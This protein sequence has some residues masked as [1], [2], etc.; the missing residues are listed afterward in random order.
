MRHFTQAIAYTRFPLPGYEIQRM[1]MGDHLNLYYNFWLLKD[2]LTH[3]RNPFSDPYQFTYWG[4]RFFNPQIALFSV[5]FAFLSPMGNGVAFNLVF[6]LSFMLA[7]GCTFLWL[8]KAGISFWP[9][10]LGGTIYCLAPHR[11]S[12]MCGHINGLFYFSFPL[13][14]Y[15]AEGMAGSSKRGYAIWMGGILLI[16]AWTEYH[17]F[18]YTILFLIPYG[19]FLVDRM[20]SAYGNTGPEGIGR[21]LLLL[22][23]GGLGCLVATLAYGH[24]WPYGK[25]YFALI[26]IFA[27]GFYLLG[28]SL[29][30]IF[31]GILTKGSAAVGREGVPVL[32]IPFGLLVLLPIKFFLPIPQFGHILIAL[33][34]AG[35]GYTVWRVGARL[36]GSRLNKTKVR[37]LR[38][39]FFSIL[40]FLLASGGIVV[41]IKTFILKGTIVSR[42]R[43]LAE[44]RY[45]SPH[46]HNLFQRVNYAGESMVYLGIVSLT[47]VVLSM[48][49]LLANLRTE[50][51]TG[52]L[53]RQERFWLGIFF[54]FTFLSLGLSVPAVPLYAFFYRVVPYFKYPRVPGRLI[55]ISYAA[56]AFCA[57]WAIERVRM[58]GEWIKVGL[59]M[60]LTAG[61]AWDY[62]PPRPIG[63]C[64]LDR[65]KTVYSAVD[66]KGMPPATLLELPVWPGDSA[67]STLYQYYVTR[68][69]YPMVNGY[70]P[71][72]PK[73]YVEK[74][75]YGLYPM[76]V[77]EASARSRELLQRLQ[78]KYVTFHAE[79][80]PYKIC[81]FPPSLALKRLRTL[82][83]LRQVRT[84]SRMTLFKVIP[85]ALKQVPDKRILETVVSPVGVLWEAERA[86]HA[87]GKVIMDSH[88][89]G[90]KAL[91][92]LK[93]ALRGMM[94]GN[95][96]RFFPSG[97]YEGVAR[98]KVPAGQSVGNAPL[99]V[100]LVTGRHRRVTLM[101]RFISPDRVSPGVYTDIRFEFHVPSAQKI[102]CIVYSDGG[103]PLC[104]DYVYIAFRGQGE[105]PAVFQAEDLFHLAP[106]LPMPGGKGWGVRFSPRILNDRGM[107]GPIHRLMP[108]QYR[109]SFYMEVEGK[110]PD[111]APVA[112][113]R[114]TRG[115]QRE[116][117]A[118]RMLRRAD[119]KAPHVLQPF[120]L[121][122]SLARPSILEF[123]VYYQGG[124]ILWVDRIE[125][126]K[127]AAP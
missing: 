51:R 42:G 25:G 48:G 65:G 20:V 90:G 72:V 63:L 18:Y 81:P 86:H 64:L 46:F 75:F 49:F 106:T 62:F 26:P 59:V 73:D 93:P 43:S 88:A 16:M 94:M 85:T 111:G 84:S 78:V 77:G 66:K 121:A 67:W 24:R 55:F 119:W 10:V 1:N 30:R 19:L 116:V 8:R 89:S 127:N 103:A 126:A 96:N 104:L 114:V 44:V 11:L 82:P 107:S 87:I 34:A 36:R 61:I 31:S 22:E 112:L 101:K 58:K 118:Q 122:I 39:K 69:R 12:Q 60:M 23:G 5:L 50:G 41:L 52:G 124:G 125:V 29:S 57:A 109:I 38:V 117:L 92:T 79:A 120:T 56:L 37:M 80:Y 54:L 15:F 83:F 105:G 47:L 17:M 98:I 7:G 2:N 74:V 71:V 95:Q 99:G 32:F 123:P 35:A 9:A 70:S 6:L 97:W 27:A 113:I 108:G 3:F 68:Y 100:I 21:G 4:K 28:M 76:D 91:R 33:T 14:L 102:E 45:F 115:L 53:V 13:L 110:V 40:P